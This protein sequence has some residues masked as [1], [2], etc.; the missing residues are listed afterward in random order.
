MS[1]G[2]LAGKVTVIT[3]GASGLGATTARRFAEEGA[4]VVCVDLNADD[5]RTVAASLGDDAFG[6]GADV[7]DPIAMETVAAETFDR[8]GRIDVLFANAG[9][10]GEGAAHSI[11]V[12]QWRNVLSVNLDGVF[13]SVRAVLPYM[14]NQSSGS[15]ILQ[16]SLAG[17]KGVPNLAAYSA[18]KAGVIGL[19]RQLA[20]EYAP[21]G[22]R[23]NAICPGTILTPLVE[24]A[25]EERFGVDGTAAA[26]E[27]RAQD[28]PLGRL[29]I[30]GEIAD[31]AVYLA[32]D[33]S[34]WTTGTVL[35]IDGGIDARM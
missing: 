31:Y 11:P 14:S 29:G 4:H 13:Y 18:A 5:A 22:I 7:T 35:P 17:L 21:E 2:R 27:R 32:S 20:I 33:E 23:C 30:P 25:Y 19:A 12:E 6:L 34:S 16:S 1:D 3:G 28:Y 15:L 26:L 9:I 10:P 8:Y 24:Q